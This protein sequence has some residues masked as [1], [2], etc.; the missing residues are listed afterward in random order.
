MKKLN[1]IKDF[2]M[3]ENNILKKGMVEIRGGSL[4]PA[5]NDRTFGDSPRGIDGLCDTVERKDGEI[6]NVTRHDCKQ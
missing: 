2:K 1:S 5:T 6:V 3:K 4:P